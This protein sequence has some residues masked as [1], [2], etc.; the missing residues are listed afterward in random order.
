MNS[1]T[2]FNAGICLIVIFIDSLFS[3]LKHTGRKIRASV[4]LSHGGHQACPHPRSVPD[5]NVGLKHCVIIIISR[6]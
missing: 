5:G 4:T 2:F 3:S 6:V 1:V